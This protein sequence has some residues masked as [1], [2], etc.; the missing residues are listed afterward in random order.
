ML[1]FNDIRMSKQTKKFNFSQ[2]PGSI[3]HVLK[4][5]IDLLNRYT[6]SGMTV[7][8]RT[9]DT[10]T[11]FANDFLDLIPVSLSILGEKICL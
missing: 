6:L 3:R 8:R 4:N 9:N 2:N 11:S 10:V 7:D 5:I 1:D